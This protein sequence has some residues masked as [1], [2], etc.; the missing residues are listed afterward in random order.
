MTKQPQPGLFKIKEG[1][2]QQWQDWCTELQTSLALEASKTIREEG[3]LYEFFVTFE[4][5]GSHYTLGAGIVAD[6][7]QMR[8]ADPVNT[9]N[10]QHIKMKSEC[11]EFI[12]KGD[13]NYLLKALDE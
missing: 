13:F 1:K 2:L 12:G 4:I 8:H 9:I 3:E 5:D 10:Q 11:L 6:G 7:Q